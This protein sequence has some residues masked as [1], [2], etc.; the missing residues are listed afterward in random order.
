MHLKEQYSVYLSRTVQCTQKI[1]VQC[2]IA[3]NTNKS[4][5]VNMNKERYT[6]YTK[7]KYN[8]NQPKINKN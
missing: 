5:T 1:T 7:K 4:G 6:V 2:K 8:V 3:K